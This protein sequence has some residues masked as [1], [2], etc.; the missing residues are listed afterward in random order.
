MGGGEGEAE[1]GVIWAIFYF[2]FFFSCTMTR[3]HPFFLSFC[4]HHHHCRRGMSK[5]IS[6]GTRLSLILYFQSLISSV[7]DRFSVVE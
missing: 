6:L 4:L 3:P 5:F 1:A 2:L 7:F